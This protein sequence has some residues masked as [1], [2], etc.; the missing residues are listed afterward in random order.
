MAHNALVSEI[1]MQIDEVA[2]LMSEFGLTEATYEGPGWKVSLSR[3]PAPQANVP[4]PTGEGEALAAVHSA[5]VA[6]P[7]VE[8]EVPKGPRGTPVNSPMNGIFYASP[9]PS[10]PAFVKEGDTVQAGQV[11]GLIEAMKVFNEI[12]AIV[13]GTVSKIAAGNGA[14]VATGDPLVYIE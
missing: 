7:T 13:S 3:A 6:M 11:I 12:T 2:A 14:L 8:V 5:F 1:S 4:A 10:A 9:S